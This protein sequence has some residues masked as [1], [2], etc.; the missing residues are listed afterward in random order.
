MSTLTARF[1]IAGWDPQPLA[2]LAEADW[3]AA[4]VMRKTFTAGLVGSSV[5]HF[6]SSGDE[7]NGRGYLA[8]ERITGRTDDG[9]E[10][11]FTVHHGALSSPSDPSAFGHVIPG[12]GTGGFAGLTGTARIHHDETGPYFVF[13]L[14]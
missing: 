4:V 10:G 9:R 14:A 12:S 13:D 5:A 11:S 2:G 7:A 3:V 6:V 1:S 8:I